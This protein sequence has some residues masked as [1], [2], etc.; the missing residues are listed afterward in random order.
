MICG[1]V[2]WIQENILKIITA[3][4]FLFAFLVSLSIK[5]ENRKK[6][7]RLKREEKCK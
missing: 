7:R 5:W 1:P 2:C 3:I 4:P 6:K